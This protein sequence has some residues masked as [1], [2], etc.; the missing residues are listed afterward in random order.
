VDVLVL[1]ALGLGD[2]LA[3]V[4]ALR[5]LRR[6]VEGR[7]V[8]AGPAAPGEL[9]R[10]AGVVDE[11]VA[12]VG[13]DATVPRG[14]TWAVNLHGR[15][16]QS[17]RLLL[18]AQPRHLVGFAVPDLGL[19]GPT[20]RADE[21]ER[22]RWCRLVTTTWPGTP[23]DP[24][25]VRLAPPPGA[26]GTRA[27][28]VHPGA[29]SA[30]RRWPVERWAQVVRA[31][32]AAGHDVV[33]TGTSAERGIA[34][35]L[36]TAAGLPAGAVRAGDTALPDLVRLVADAAAVLSGD[37]G[38]AHLAFAYGTPS[39]T[40]YG[41][42]PPRWWGPPPGPHAALWHGDGPGDPH[43]D[44]PDAALL[45]VEPAEVLVALADVA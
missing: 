5:A 3:A 29:A 31:L 39:V 38:V 32:R 8:L 34:A 23:A 9:L 43:A 35:S 36:A 20:W 40:L 21:P 18:A 6:A 22:A 27:V 44:V 24:D 2:T 7:L 11:V 10:A 1:R 26:P 17:H 19:T 28:V 33:V 37:T 15:G 16:P 4:P 25:D 45:R 41:P 42:T 13:L 14:A 12:A 30:A